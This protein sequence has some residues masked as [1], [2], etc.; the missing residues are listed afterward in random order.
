MIFQIVP[1]NSS[2]IPVLAELEKMC[3]SAPWS[4]SSLREELA[5][6]L[7]HFLAAVAEEKTAGY[8]GV[9]EVAG[10]GYITNI[11]VFPEYRRQGIAQALLE[12]AEAGAG[13]RGCAFLTLEVRASNKAAAAL[14]SKMGYTV[15]GE[16]KN[17]YSNPAEN[18]LLMTKQLR[19]SE[20]Q[21]AG[22]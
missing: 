6:P 7:S 10:E 14:Y 19:K 17:F 5:N 15:T 13:E 12:A 3:F 11:A 20:E 1:M 21:N 4:E 8:L 9:Q 22:I 2:H 18:A 16:R